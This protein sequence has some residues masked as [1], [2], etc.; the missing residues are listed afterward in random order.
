MGC[1]APRSIAAAT[2]SASVSQLGLQQDSEDGWWPR[3]GSIALQRSSPVVNVPV[4][5]NA[6]ISQAASASSTS[7]PFKRIPCGRM[8]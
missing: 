4:L 7:P 3:S 6:T 2:A 1:V 8:K 5:S